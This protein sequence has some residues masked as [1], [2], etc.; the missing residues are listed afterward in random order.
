MPSAIQKLGQR[1]IVQWAVAYVLGAWILLQV[2]ESLASI[3]SL[4]GDLLRVLVVLSVFGFI[5]TLVISWFHGEKGHQGLSL[6]ELALLIAIAIITVGFVTT[7]EFNLEGVARPIPDR[8]GRVS[9][10]RPIPLT[11]WI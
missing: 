5:A 4:S 2:A 3:F 9:G 8:P 1:R 7:V 6:L 11:E 10:L